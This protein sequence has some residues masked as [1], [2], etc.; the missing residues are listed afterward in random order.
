M[1]NGSVTI[2]AAG[3]KSD[4]I[5]V[6]GTITLNGGHLTITAADDCTNVVPTDNA[7]VLTCN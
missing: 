4:G 3:T 2:N 1:N 7:N 6:D 5:N